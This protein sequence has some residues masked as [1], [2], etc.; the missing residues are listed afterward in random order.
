MSRNET[1]SIVTSIIT[2]TIL[3]TGGEDHYHKVG[4]INN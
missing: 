2:N 4:L 1:G 3:F